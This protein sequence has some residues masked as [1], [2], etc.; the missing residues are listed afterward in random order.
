MWEPDE[1][2]V[3]ARQ[4][5]QQIFLREGVQLMHAAQWLDKKQ[6]QKTSTR[7]CNAICQS[8]I[9]AVQLRDIVQPNFEHEPSAKRP[10]LTEPE[11]S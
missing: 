9:E 10:P 8:L 5:A 4:R 7:L 3:W 11:P 6:T 2:E 1:L